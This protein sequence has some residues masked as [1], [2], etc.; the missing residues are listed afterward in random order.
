VL[1]F[2]VPFF[3][4]GGYDIVKVMSLRKKISL[5]V[6]AGLIIGGGF[7]YLWLSGRIQIK[8][9]VTGDCQ[10][11]KKVSSF[12][13]QPGSH[14]VTYNFFGID[15]SVHELVVPYLDNIQ[16]ETKAQGIDYKIN[17][18]DSFNNRSIRGGGKSM[19]SWGTAFDINP[20]QNP[21]WGNKK[22]EMQRDIPDSLI[23][24]FKTNGFF[25]GGD[26]AGNRDPMHFEWYPA[27]VSGQIIDSKSG[28][29]VV[30]AATFYDGVPITNTNGA[31]SWTLPYGKHA[32][33]A[34]AEGYPDQKIDLDLAC[35]NKAV[36]NI[37]MEPYSGEVGA[38]ISGHVNNYSQYAFFRAIGSVYLDGQ[39]LTSVDQNDNYLIRG[40]PVGD[41]QVEVRFLFIRAGATSIKVVTP[42]ANMSGVDITIGQ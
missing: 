4:R 39:A 7:L 17:D 28:Q 9:D 41:H 13:G 22:G 11:T 3:F 27:G 21:Y 38:T 29:P 20:Q 8:A 30:G 33:S 5:I 35:F 36:A 26:W 19:H 15:L 16:A 23:N 37:T 1:Y 40:V 34:Q 10:G 32:I 24:I 2:F 18:I 6:L 25:W 12:L 31:F 14:L 42:G